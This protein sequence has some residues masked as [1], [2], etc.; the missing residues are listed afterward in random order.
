[1]AGIEVSDIE[2][3]NSQHDDTTTTKESEGVQAKVQL[4]MGEGVSTQ[5]LVS[6]S[7]WTFL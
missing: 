1:M 2:S 4:S 6:S 5:M 7:T 3:D